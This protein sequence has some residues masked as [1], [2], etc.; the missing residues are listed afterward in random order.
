[1]CDVTLNFQ[2][3]TLL[4]SKG[5]TNNDLGGGGSG[6]EFVLSIFSS[7]KLVFFPEGRVVNFCFPA[8][9]RAP[10]PRSMVRP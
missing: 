7:C 8:F 10:P 1:M 9:A 4:S 6:R 2:I 5:Q 3:H